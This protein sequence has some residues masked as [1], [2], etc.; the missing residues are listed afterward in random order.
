MNTELLA[1]LLTSPIALALLALLVE[2]WFPWPEQWHPFAV[3]RLM[4]SYM[5]GKVNPPGRSVSQQRLA[6]FL[7]WLTLSLLVLLPAAIVFAGAE[8]SLAIGW[9]ILLVSLRQQPVAHA[10]KLADNHLQ[11]GRKNAAR[12]WL[13]RITWRDCDLLSKHGIAKTSLEL[14]A[15]S[16]LEH[17]FTPLLFWFVGGPLAALGVRAIAELTQVW[18]VAQARYRQFGLTTHWLYTLTHFFPSFFLSLVARL[19]TLFQPN[20]PKLQPLQRNLLFPT[21][22]LS[23]LQSFSY[24]HRVT[25][26]GPIQVEGI[27]LARQRF[28]GRPA[29]L[30]LPRARRWQR[31]WQFF[32]VSCLVIAFFALFIYRP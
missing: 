24:C 6:G 23:W 29:E 8:L 20:K 1:Q 4:A 13:S 32:F 3:L 30:L 25:L 7:A 12:A 26:G 21:V 2:R 5:S 22:L 14:R 11:C 31:Q 10:V 28:D 17:R 27:R 9:L 19:M 15:A 16:I 18:P